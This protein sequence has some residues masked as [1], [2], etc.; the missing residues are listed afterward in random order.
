MHKIVRDNNKLNLT[1]QKL[2]STALRLQIYDRIQ[3]NSGS[4]MQTSS[5]SSSRG[6]RLIMRQLNN[7]NLYKVSRTL[8]ARCLVLLVKPLDCV[9]IND[10][11]SYGK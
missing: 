11:P 5:S 4:L 6:R 7:A 2:H 3:S 10:H 8:Y 1:Q 9:V